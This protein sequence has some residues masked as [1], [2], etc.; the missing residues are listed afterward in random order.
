MMLDNGEMM[1]YTRGDNLGGKLEFYTYYVIT[2]QS[3][4][5]VKE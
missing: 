2:D 1:S 3:R 5:A 4:G